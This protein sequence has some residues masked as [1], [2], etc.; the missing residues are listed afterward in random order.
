MNYL[1]EELYAAEEYRLLT[2]FFVTSFKK[3]N[4]TKK[5]YAHDYN[6]FRAYINTKYRRI[7]MYNLETTDIEDFFDNIEIAYGRSVASTTKER[8]YDQLHRLYEYFIQQ[9]IITEN[10]LNSI[11]KHAGD[12]KIKIEKLMT[13]EEGVKLIKSINSMELREKTMLH[14]LFTSAPKVSELVALNWNHFFPDKN[15]TPGYMLKK[16]YREY[17]KKIHEDVFRLLIDYKVST[18][19][20]DK[21]DPTDSSPVFINS[22]GKRISESWVRKSVYSA[23]EIAGIEQYSPSDLRNT[24]AAILLGIGVPAAEVAE[25]MGYSDSF[26]VKRLPIIVQNTIDH[27]P[28]NIKDDKQ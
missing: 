7:P 14:L 26:L 22:N 8:V 23:C 17:F 15:G 9:G 6:V 3:E 24:N 20:G 13:V 1:K 19:R 10:P 2:T 16:G 4:K 28:F 27:L 21:I 18:S 25:H 5:N 12:K 11:N